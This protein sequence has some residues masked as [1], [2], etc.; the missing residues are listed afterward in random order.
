MKGRHGAE[1]KN[2]SRLEM[3]QLT[4]V[5]SIFIVNVENRVD[6]D[7]I[8]IGVTLKNNGEFL[9]DGRKAH[10]IQRFKTGMPDKSLF[11]L[12][13]EFGAL[14]FLDPPPLPLERHYFVNKAFP[15]IVFPYMRE[16]VAETTRKGG[17]T[18]LII[19]QNLFDYYDE[20]KEAVA[21][22]SDDH[23]WVH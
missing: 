14:F 10:Y 9:D 5:K 4:L 20:E 12:D 8:A 6:T 17:F 19:N 1:M 11:F 22:D 15:R 3:A 2:Q 16:H 18:P 13:V 7:R 23:K 21:S